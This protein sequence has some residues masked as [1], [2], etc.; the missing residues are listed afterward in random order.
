MSNEDEEKQAETQ[1]LQEATRALEEKTFEAT[2]TKLRLWERDRH[3][4]KKIQSLESRVRL[5]V[6]LALGLSLGS[7]AMF[8]FLVKGQVLPLSDRIIA[9]Q[10]RVGPLQAR[11]DEFV[12]ARKTD[13]SK[14]SPTLDETTV[15]RLEKDV[16]ESVKKLAPEILAVA[17][18]GSEPVSAVNRDSEIKLRAAV[19]AAQ[20][21]TGKALR[22][23][24]GQTD[25]KKTEWV[26]YNHGGIYVD[27]DTSSAGF[28]S[29]PYYFT[30]MSGHTNNWMAQGVTSIYFPTAKGF[31]VHVGYRELTAEQAKK[32]GWSISW[33]AIGN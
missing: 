5:L 1:A 25:P 6:W 9:L 14:T 21:A 24:V 26:Q 7:A 32:W 31:R 8:A 2:D 17:I 28:S 30:S 22:L 20:G 29:T 16:L 12:Q 3:L 27:I 19:G 15:K 10:E 4:H 33:I 11:I 13:V 23:V 18:K